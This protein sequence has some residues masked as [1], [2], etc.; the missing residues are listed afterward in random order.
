[1]A[2]HGRAAPRGVMGRPSRGA[3]GHGRDLY[4]LLSAR[5]GPAAPPLMKGFLFAVP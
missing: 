2:M 3:Y 1:M 5:Q 4:G